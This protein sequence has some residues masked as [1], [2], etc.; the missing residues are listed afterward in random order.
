M[1]R[2]KNE[3]GYVL[4]YLLVAI[5]LITTLVVT[6]F[7]LFFLYDKYE[8]RKYNK[9]K[10]D[11]ACYS[12]VQK[13]IA[14]DTLDFREIETV[15]IDSTSVELLIKQKGLYYTVTA[16][17]KSKKDSSK[18]EYLL[19]ERMREPFD[20]ALIITRPSLNAAVTGKTKIIGNILGT[21][22][23]IDK[24]RIFG[25][26]QADSNYLTGSIKTD[27]MLFQKLYKDSLLLK[28]FINWGMS[29]DKKT[30]TLY[31]NILVDKDFVSRY[32][33]VENIIIKGNLTFNGTITAAHNSTKRIY[34]TGK[35]L[36]EQEA[37]IKYNTEVYCDS[38][39]SIKRGATL[40]NILITSK[41]KIVA[42]P[43]VKCKNVQLISQ[44]GIECNS[45]VLKFPSILCLYINPG[46]TSKQR[47]KLSI[48]KSKINGTVMLLSSEIAASTNKSKI[49]IDSESSVHGV[50]YSE[51]N[52]EAYGSIL[53]AIYT[54]NVLYYKK[55]TEYVNWLVDMKIDRTRLDKHF[56]MP[57]GFNNKPQLEI[58]K[59]TW[60]N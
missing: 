1:L 19:A 37:D 39:V 20:N 6:M 7:N 35:T 48:I 9:K 26:A 53:G 36:I 56:L 22:K 5:L 8:I 12:A 11:L 29:E 15:L 2:E 16:T 46:D 41:S 4:P 18:V 17:A 23:K 47:S 40:E 14:E 24:G 51:N 33:S 57:V 52:V 58:L 21:T 13:L 30:I 10:L 44:R 34:V 27:P 50:V 28:E 25:I 32:D 31:E 55:P 59:E 38:T 42:E 45:I 49:L 3:S 43:L 60:I 54:N